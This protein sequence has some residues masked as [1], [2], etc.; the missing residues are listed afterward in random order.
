MR[1]WI[2]VG[3][4]VSILLPSKA[5]ADAHEARGVDPLSALIGLAFLTS[6]PVGIWALAHYS[7]KLSE[8]RQDKYFLLE[9]GERPDFGRS[10]T[11]GGFLSSDQL[12][13][14]RYSQTSDAT[15]KL[16]F[17]TFEGG[18]RHYLSILFGEIG[19]FHANHHINDISR[20]SRGVSYPYQSNTYETEGVYAALGVSAHFLNFSG[21][22]RCIGYEGLSKRTIKIQE[23]RGI[24]PESAEHAEDEFKLKH[25]CYLDVGLAF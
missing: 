8:S 12:L 24:V 15:V 1:Q 25:A 10:Y 2:C 23:N 21:G 5:W 9:R 16:K 20:D 17:K 18:Y 4:L 13:L 14:G 6:I 7:E 3:L 22:I 19:A 11:V